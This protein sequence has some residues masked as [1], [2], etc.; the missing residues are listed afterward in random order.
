MMDTYS[1]HKAYSVPDVVTG[2]PLSTGGSMGR[3]MPR[4][5][6]ARM[7]TFAATSTPSTPSH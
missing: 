2:K 7:F 4:D 1:M 3:V 5:A 6:A